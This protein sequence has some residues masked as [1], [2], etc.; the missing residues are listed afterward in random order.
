MTGETIREILKTIYHHPLFR[1]VAVT[2]GLVLGVGLLA[3]L[4][5]MPMYTRHGEPMMV[6]D[7]TAVPIDE[8]K[9]RL[10]NSGFH[11]VAGEERF[12]SECPNGYVLEQTPRP[13]SNVKG[14][15]RIYLVV[16]RGE[17]LVQ[18]PMLVER[19]ERDAQLLLSRYGLILG[20]VNYE[21]S[22]FYPEGTISFQSLA[23]RSEV[24]PGTRVSIT[25]S[26]GPLPNEFVVPAVSGRPFDDA[27]KMIRKAGLVVGTVRY[28]DV[29]DLLPETVIGQSI[30]AGAKVDKGTKIDLVV[31]RL[32][33][34]PQPR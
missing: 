30:E 5:I 1:F 29:A 8:A 25:V 11:A 4:A 28:E 7:V 23:P 15:R 21:Y 9:T 18:M 14:G 6:P 27:A 20:E 32:P 26:A 2:A 10:E 3:D 22:S 16:S 33:D 24:A 19:S 17:R 31:S 12:S 34:N 13:H